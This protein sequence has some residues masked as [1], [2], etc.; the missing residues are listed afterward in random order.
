MNV[1]GVGNQQA[2]MHVKAKQEDTKNITDIAEDI[3]AA[4][5]E[6]VQAG[7]AQTDGEGAQGVL[8]LIQAGHFNGVADVRL[9]INFY[10]ELQQI[11]AQNTGQALEGGAQELT[12]NLTAELEKIGTEFELPAETEELAAAFRERMD[13]IIADTKDGK[14]DLTT[15]LA[16]M[17]AE[18]ATLLDAMKAAMT[19]S[20]E[21]VEED[22]AAGQADQEEAVPQDAGEAVVAEDET[23][24]ESGVIEEEPMVPFETRLAELEDWFAT[25]MSTLESSATA[26]QASQALPP[27]SAPRG[28][29]AAYAKFLE[30]YENMGSGTAQNTGTEAAIPAVELDAQA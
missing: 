24:E 18:F 21:P 30:I 23:P 3:A 11:S 15:A 9:R 6:N 22:E 19:E 4:A 29:G 26:T 10:D 13:Q 7:D 17:R 14:T 2:W 20:P 8:R 1:Q 28:N 12:T 5:T 25:A 27:L 16:S